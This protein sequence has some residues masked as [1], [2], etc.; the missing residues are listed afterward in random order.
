M[1]ETAM[2]PEFAG[3]FAALAERRIAFPKCR[4]CGRFHWYPMPRCP[5]CRGGA[6]Q[7][8]AVEGPARI[9]SFTEVRHAFDK[10]NRDRLPYIVALVTFPDAPGVR[11]VTNIVEA[12]AEALSID[13]IV[14]PRFDAGMPAR[15]VFRP[16][17]GRGGAK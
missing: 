3:F 15:V 4:D 10:S 1:S 5:H 2:E 9:Y 13:D 8:A 12:S 7:W 16:A 17:T 11:L 14:E 6:I